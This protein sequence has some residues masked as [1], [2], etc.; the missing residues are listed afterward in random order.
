MSDK[1]H[2]DVA[3]VV[4]NIRRKLVD[5]VPSGSSML[6]LLEAVC[7]DAAERLNGIHRVVFTSPV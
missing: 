4:W 7:P 5:W 2:A 1:Y 6:K 3:E